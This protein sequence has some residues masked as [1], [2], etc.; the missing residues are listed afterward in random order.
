MFSWKNMCV[1]I[2][3][4]SENISFPVFFSKAYLPKFVQVSRLSLISA[5][6]SRFQSLLSE[7]NTLRL[8]LMSEKSVFQHWTFILETISSQGHR[9][10]WSKIFSSVLHGTVSCWWDF[11]LSLPVN[12]RS[13]CNQWNSGQRAAVAQPIGFI[14]WVI[15]SY[16]ALDKS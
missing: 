10:K 4:I 14:S 13:G 7:W 5:F 9:L 12:F 15:N 11:G 1:I 16:R 2:I 3:R 6:S 8:K